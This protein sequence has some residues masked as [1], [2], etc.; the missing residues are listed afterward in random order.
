MRKPVEMDTHDLHLNMY[1]KQDMCTII[2]IIGKSTFV[3]CD[4]MDILLRY[5]IPCMCHI[6]ERSG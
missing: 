3:L 6:S 4:G 2:I 5:L 1:W